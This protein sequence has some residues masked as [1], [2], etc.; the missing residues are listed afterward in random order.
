M[1]SGILSEI[2]REKRLAKLWG[3]SEA[4]DIVEKTEEHRWKHFLRA[5]GAATPDFMADYEKPM[6]SDNRN[7]DW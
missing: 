7:L 5:A 6:D 2:N 3:F 1:L 4:D